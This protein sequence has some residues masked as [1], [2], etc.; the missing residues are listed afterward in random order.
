MPLDPNR[1]A[2]V[3]LHE[4]YGD[5]YVLLDN[6]ARDFPQM[7]VKVVRDRAERHFYAGAKEQPHSDLLNLPLEEVLANPQ[8]VRHAV[9]FFQSRSD[10]E[11]EGYSVPSF[12]TVGHSD[13]N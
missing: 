11:Y 5:R 9:K 4:K 1:T 13:D 2:L 8:L 3:V 10:G 7:I 12:E 6:Y